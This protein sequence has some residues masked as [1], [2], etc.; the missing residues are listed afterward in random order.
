MA[1][2]R[3]FPEFFPVM[4]SQQESG[5]CGDGDDEKMKRFFELIGEMREARSQMMRLQEREVDGGRQS[6]R[7]KV[8]CC[9]S[10]GEGRSWV[11]KF[12]AEDFGLN[13]ES[14]VAVTCSSPKA[15][16]KVGVREKIEEGGSG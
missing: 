4:E 5:G 2:S 14:G 11:P 8:D 12:E 9:C 13:T 10:E 15:L 7:R 16:R 3:K 6:K 1:A